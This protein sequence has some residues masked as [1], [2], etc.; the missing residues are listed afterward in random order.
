M[1]TKQLVLVATFDDCLVYVD[2]V[3]MRSRRSGTSP[4]RTVG[5]T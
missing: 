3:Q 5:R 2:D 1:T 4:S